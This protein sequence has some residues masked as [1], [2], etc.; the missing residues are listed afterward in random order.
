[1]KKP[2]ILLFNPDQWRGDV[3]GHLGTADGTTPFTDSL[4]GSDAVSFAWTFTQAT[5]C[6]PSRCAFS[7]GLYPHVH[8]HRSL[9]HMLHDERGQTNMFKVLRE[10]G[11]FVW[12]GGKN[13]LV[14]GEEGPEAH[15]DIHFKPDEAFFER[16]GAA[17]VPDMHRGDQSWRGAPGSDTYYSF[18]RGELKTPD[19]AA[20]Y[21]DKDWQDVLGAC[22]FIRQAP[23]DKPLCIYLPILFPHPP[24]GAE[25]EYLTQVAGTDLLPRRHATDD[26]LARKAGMLSGIRSGQGLTGWSEE[27]WEE[28]RRTY[29]AMIARVDAQFRMVVEALKEAGFYDDTAIFLFSDHGDYTGDYEVVEKNQNTFED[30]LSRVP[31]VVKPPKDRPCTP[32]VRDA[33][34]AQL[35]DLPATLYDLAGID[36]GYDHF[37]KSLLPA[38][39]DRNTPHRD[40]AFCEGGRRPDEVQASERESLQQFG[41]APEVGHY[42]PRISL[43]VA[44]PDLHNRA[45]MVR[46]LD[47]KYIRRTGERDEFYDLAADPME[48]D[49]RIDDP[50]C[51]ARIG[52]LK[53]RLLD[54]YLETSDT[55][56]RQTDGR[57]RS[58]APAAP[59]TRA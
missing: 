12:W 10:N 30:P 17:P 34:L 4:V 46:S 43:Q 31:M 23:R 41:D 55:L 8:G 52:E 16:H 45:V 7:T 50:A 56:P 11:Y 29:Y 20:H 37:G 21:L 19:G 47:A 2:H 13:D 25:T 1:M 6:T 38:V 27:R 39:A 58:P 42:Y 26:Q 32:G 28:L 40:L 22:E 44:R 49:N 36:P 57:W 3:M 51:A 33:T 15:S 9:H 5:V 48:L 18:L 14:P 54:W 24:Y 53:E 59:E 35:I